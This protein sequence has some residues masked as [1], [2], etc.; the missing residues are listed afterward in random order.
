MFATTHICFG[1]QISGRVQSKVKKESEKAI[2]H[3]KDEMS[4]EKD[5]ILVEF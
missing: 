1:S 3:L 4:P 2:K 5:E